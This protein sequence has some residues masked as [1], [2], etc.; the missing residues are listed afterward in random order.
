MKVTIEALQKKLLKHESNITS[1]WILQDV[2][3]FPKLPMLLKK[4]IYS[5][6]TM[7][8][9]TTLVMAWFLKPLGLKPGRKGFAGWEFQVNSADFIYTKKF[10][11]EF[12]GCDFSLADIIEW[13]SLSNYGS[14]K[15]G[16]LVKEIQKT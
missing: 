10:L 7:R 8:P 16:G 1:K 3:T 9:Y 2:S 6:N 5:A 11:T 12:D 15:R 13:S 14:K 4:L